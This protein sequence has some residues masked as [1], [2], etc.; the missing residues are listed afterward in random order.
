M[1][2]VE[3]LARGMGFARLRLDTRKD[4]VESQRLYESLGYRETP[5]H[6]GGPYSDRWYGKL[7][8]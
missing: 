1:L 8:G 6:S 4:L 5:P 2:E 7:L 3:E